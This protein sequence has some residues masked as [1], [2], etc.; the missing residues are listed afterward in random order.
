M[1]RK[2]EINLSQALTDDRGAADEILDR[3]LYVSHDIK[4]VLK[5]YNL[6]LGWLRPLA[7]AAHTLIAG[8]TLRIPFYL[9]H[10]FDVAC[11]ALYF[12]GITEAPAAGPDEDDDAKDAR[13]QGGML[14]IHENNGQVALR[15]A[16]LHDQFLGLIHA[17]GQQTR[18]LDKHANVL[19]DHPDDGTGGRPEVS[20]GQLRRMLLK[21]LPATTVRWGHKVRTVT[22]L[23][24]GR[25]ELSFAN[26]TTVQTML[27][28]G[29]DGAW[30]KVRPLLR[31]RPMSLRR[32]SASSLRRACSPSSR[33]TTLP[34]GPLLSIKMRAGFRLERA[35][36]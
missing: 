5:R 15:A 1:A 18:V 7:S 29:A 14:D 33:E 19:L 13:T 24:G 26:G 6:G 20:R 2:H 16:G 32:A 36:H 17:G 9:A 28:I 30:S 11:S 34:R 31:K 35:S 12:P 10:K 21:S 4:S 23:G 3:V 25:H 8:D 27:L 22:S